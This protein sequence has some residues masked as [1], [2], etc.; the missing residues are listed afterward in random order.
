MRR[1]FTSFLLLILV[2]ELVTLYE[3]NR[4]KSHTDILAETIEATITPVASLAATSIPTPTPTPV[5]TPEVTLVPTSSPKP[6]P[7]Q[8]PKTVYSSEQI[9][10]FID[11]FSGM[12][13]V[14]PHLVRKIAICE[15]G[16]NTYAV[17]G[18][19]AGLF[20]FGTGSWSST[21]RLLGKSGAPELRFNPEEAIQTAAFALSLGKA[22][23]WPNCN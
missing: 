11:R 22:G 6:T 18:G 14:N 3:M 20:Q 15:S 21:R 10:I 7:S 17:N 1:A 9:N 16:F 23:L 4:S 2:V 13:G 8:S 5:P 12:Y 19:Y